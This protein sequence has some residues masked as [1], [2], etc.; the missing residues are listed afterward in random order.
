MHSLVATTEAKQIILSLILMF[1]T[2][3]VTILGYIRRIKLIWIISLIFLII[4][5]VSRLFAVILLIPWWAYLAIFG[6]A[7]IIFAVYMLVKMQ[8][9][10]QS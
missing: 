9:R 5:F 2:I 1:A 8:N 7:V 3:F 6:L 10:T 4:A